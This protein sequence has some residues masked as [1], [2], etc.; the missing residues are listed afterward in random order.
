MANEKQ[1]KNT[2]NDQSS[3]ELENGTTGT[4]NKSSPGFFKSIGNAVS[5]IGR[6]IKSVAWDNKIGK[7][8]TITGAI[9]SAGYGTKVLVESVQNRM[10]ENADNELARMGH[11]MSNALLDD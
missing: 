3:L 6:N 10:D 2:T 4:E 8:V 11:A 1:T 7:T 5:A 9:L